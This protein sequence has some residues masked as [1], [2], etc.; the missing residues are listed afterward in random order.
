MDL[1][2]TLDSA[3]ATM[4]LLGYASIY[5]VAHAS[6]GMTEN[7]NILGWRILD[8]GSNHISNELRK[9]ADPEGRVYCPYFYGR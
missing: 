8:M 5:W 7:I 6:R 9:S 3:P 2:P 4:P 1:S